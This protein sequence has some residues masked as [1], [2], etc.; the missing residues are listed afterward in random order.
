[1]SC[2]RMQGKTRIDSIIKYSLHCLRILNHKYIKIK[3]LSKTPTSKSKASETLYLRLSCANKKV[4]S[5]QKIDHTSNPNT[6]SWMQG[7]FK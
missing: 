6:K 1:M 5:Q 2:C 4:H 7:V 3:H